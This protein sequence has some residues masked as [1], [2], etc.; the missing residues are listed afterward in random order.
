MKNN[1]K[2]ICFIFKDNYYARFAIDFNEYDK[3]TIADQTNTNGYFA[4]LSEPIAIQPDKNDFVV[5]QKPVKFNKPIKIADCQLI[6]TGQPLIQQYDLSRNTTNFIS[7]GPSDHDTFNVSALS[8]NA[9]R[10]YQQADQLFIVPK[11]EIY[12]N[13][14]IVSEQQPI[15]AGSIIYFDNLELQLVNDN[16]LQV[17][18]YNPAKSIKTQLTP[19]EIQPTIF[20]TDYPEYHRSPRIIHKLPTGNI[21]IENPPSKIE[22]QKNQL[23]RTILPPL[24]MVAISIVTS[25]MSKNI[26]M[27]LMMVAMSVTTISFSISSYFSEKKQYKIDTAKRLRDYDEYLQDKTVDINHKI[28]ETTQAL[29]YHYPDLQEVAQLVLTGSSRIFE[30]NKFQNDF[31]AFR[32]GR[33]DMPATFKVNYSPKDFDKDEL[34]LEAATLATNA[35]YVHDVPITVSLLHGATGLVGRRSLVQEA[36]IN[37]LLQLVTFQSYHEVIFVPVFREKDLKA[38][39]KWR[40]LAHFKLDTNNTLSFVYNDK[41]RGQ[42]LTSLF[43]MFKEREQTQKESKNKPDQN[44]F[45]PQYVLIIDNEELVL[46]HAIMEYLAKDISELNI[47]VIFIRN[48]VDDLPEHVKNVIEYGDYHHGKIIVEN[49]E[50]VNRTFEPDHYND[51]FD[52]SLVIRRLAALDHKESLKNS[53]PEAINFLD[54]YGVKDVHELNLSNRWSNKLPYKS[55]A[56]PLGV[57]GKDDIVHLDLHER[58]H[59]PHGLVAGTTGS[60][61]SELIQSY[62]ASLAINFHPDNVGFLLIDYKGGG[63]ANLFNNLPHLLGTITNLDGAQSMRALASIKA[64][65]EKRQKLFGKYNVN[66]INQYQKLYHDGKADEAM[67]HLFL[68]SDEFAEL[69]SEQP[70]FMDELVSTARIGRSLG[71]HLI[72]A[73]QKPSGVVNE[74]I[75]SNS[76]FKISLKV[77]DKAD[78]M[79]MLHTPDAASI[80]EPGRAYLQVGNNEIYELFQ[81]AYSG[82]TY[83]PERSVDQSELDPIYR[84]NTL[85]QYENLSADLSGLTEAQP[86][87]ADTQKISELEAVINYI[88]E[89]STEHH[90]ERLPRPWLPPIASE[91]FYPDYQTI[92]Y[93][94]AWPEDLNLQTVMGIVDYPDKQSQQTLTL[95]VKE[96]KHMAVFASPGYGK[97]TFIQTFVLGLARQNSPQDINFYLLD[98]GTNGLL[99]LRDLPHVADMVRIDETEKMLKFMSIIDATI[100]QRKK[101]LSREG[102]ANYEQYVQATGTKLPVIE[103]VIDTIDS[104]KEVKWIEQFNSLIDRITREGANVAVYLLLTANRHSALRMQISAN[105][106]TQISLFL[107]D[108]SEVADIIGRTQMKPEEMAGRGLIKLD[109]VRLFQ[110]MLPNKNNNSFQMLADI[111]REA[112]QMAED[113]QGALPQSIPMVPEDMTYQQF[114]QLP[115]VT[116]TFVAGMPLGVDKET[117]ESVA[118]DIQK[119]H[120]FFILN[121]TDEQKALYTQLLQ[122][123]LQYLIQHNLATGQIIDQT[124]D[125]KDVKDNLLQRLADKES[126]AQPYYL[127]F[128]EFEDF[129]TDSNLTEDELK[130]ILQQAH[131]LNIY[132]IINTFVGYITGSYSGPVAYLKNNLKNGILGSRLTD[133]SLINNQFITNESYLQEDEAYYFKGR[134]CR[135]I[136]IPKAA[137]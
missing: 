108:D 1:T 72:L 91:I 109:T 40:W 116:D 74:Q 9:V 126:L 48:S 121:D 107:I 15:I 118:F 34:S 132:P 111:K 62:I 46:D 94:Q 99:P 33:G 92:D 124:A 16:Y 50:L 101:L 115:H 122:H 58:A 110:T 4:G 38:W 30:K 6:L 53:I 76:R 87:T 137:K 31:L 114:L 49:D 43:Q 23:A 103:I 135:K 13:H 64:E 45:S 20:S 7:L 57:R 70:D 19:L 80:V 98:F 66:H 69:K 44:Y 14:K 55:L 24:V 86:V 68:I 133:Q 75:W 100:D 97:S 113:W 2:L 131:T 130:A 21:T 35:H 105:I 36:L 67:P 129:V 54:L 136:Q 120:Y 71:I 88:G 81:S 39:K 32:V 47:S 119:R 3:F 84:I 134:N 61:K 123:N 18:N 117:T 41:T 25:M 12:V 82:G 104:A 51:T 128:E 65:L 11:G 22:K 83:N 79:E 52:L 73:T 102:V 37:M 90:I 112:Q 106:K 8:N 60:G 28:K 127:C 63:M 29:N 10:L 5:N 27:M 93:Q 26:T 77:Q 56:V 59:G 96:N 125:A 78:S 89:Y 95:D 85:G 17:A 42:I